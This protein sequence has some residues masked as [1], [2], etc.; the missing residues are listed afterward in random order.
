MTAMRTNDA[1]KDIK[2]PMKK[3]KDGKFIPD[4]HNRYLAEDVPYG[5]VVFRGMAE[6]AGVKTPAMDEILLWSQK[7]LGKEYL[8]GGELKGKDIRDTRAPQRYGFRTL[9]D[10]FRLL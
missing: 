2:H 5:V 1:L 9:T 8:V 10:L 4:F 6:I 3:T 7:I